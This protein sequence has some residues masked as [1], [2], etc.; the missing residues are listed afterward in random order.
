MNL[1]INPLCPSLLPEV[2]QCFSQYFDIDLLGVKY[3]PSLEIAFDILLNKQPQFLTIKSAPMYF[4][5]LNKLDGFN[6]ALIQS[7]AN[8]SFIPVNDSAY[9]KPSQV[10]IRSKSSFSLENVNTLDDVATRGLIDYVDYGPEANSFLFRIGVLSY[11][12]AEILAELLI[13]RQASYFS[14]N[15]KFNTDEMITAK[16]RIYTNC[17]KQLA[18]V[19]DIAQ[20]FNFEPL[21]SRLTN[22][23]WC[24]AYQ[25]ID[26][27]D[28][29]K[30]RIFQIARPE[31]IYLDDDHQSA[32]DLQ[33]LCAPDEP[34][35]TKLY[36]IFGSKWLSESVKR[37]LIHQGLSFP[38]D[39]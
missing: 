4:S 15:N 20:Q 18:V 12:S 3:R 31:D 14:P 32:I 29:N 10:F 7:I 6:R 33:P 22:Q 35:L 23:P 38:I 2:L 16:L 34:E 36:A 25:I 30:E 28:G 17:L 26:R 27:F 21:R 19:P 5:Y 11:P 13:E 37:T 8:R 24:L 1:E 9:V 39:I